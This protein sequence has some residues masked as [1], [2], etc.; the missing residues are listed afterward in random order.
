MDQI[1]YLG[2][3]LNLKLFLP[4]IEKRHCRLVIGRP[5]EKVQIVE[6]DLIFLRRID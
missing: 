2:V 1:H 5:R 4:E 6:G 3:N